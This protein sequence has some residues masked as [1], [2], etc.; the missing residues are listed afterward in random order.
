MSE[1]F[2]LTDSEYKR[3]TRRVQELIDRIEQLPY[4][5][6]RELVFE[7]LRGLD[8]LHREA[9]ARMLHRV[10]N[11]APELAERLPEDQVVR[12]LL[13]LYN[14]GPGADE[15]PEPSE[16]PDGFVAADQVDVMDDPPTQDAR[17]EIN[18]PVWIPG[19]HR[20]DL[21]PGTLMPTSFEGMN[22]LLCRVEDDIYALKNVCPGS[23]LT[24]QQGALDGHT[25]ICPWHG[26]RYDIRTGERQ[27]EPDEV[28][29]E[30]FPVEIGDDGQFS[31]GFNVRHQSTN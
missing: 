30:T 6:I 27:D 28:P 24:L 31:I 3:L 20:S 9:L 15:I 8:A 29:V 25:L 17:E 14:F 18:R 10:E 23:A 11:E 5:K 16:E 22:V 7:L 4:P 1:S 12:T 21:D 19:G 13:A 26:C 2:G